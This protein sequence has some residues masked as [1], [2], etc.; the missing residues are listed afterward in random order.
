MNFKTKI[1]FSYILFILVVFLIATQIH[2]FIHLD[3]YNVKSWINYLL[4]LLYAVLFN[5]LFVWSFELNS[6]FLKVN[7]TFFLRKSK[8][9]YLKDINTIKIFNYHGKAMIPYLEIKSKDKKYTHYF[10]LINN[11]SINEMAFEL[12]EYG[13]NVKIFNKPSDYYKK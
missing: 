10:L 13:I 8:F 5:L 1:S 2:N 12:K 3:F 9:H 4:L 11:R 6:S 7:Y